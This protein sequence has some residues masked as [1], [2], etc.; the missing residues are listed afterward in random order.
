MGTWRA[1]LADVTRSATVVARTDVELMTLDR[2]HSG[3]ELA[4]RS[5]TANTVLRTVARRMADM[6]ATSPGAAHAATGESSTWHGR[7]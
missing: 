4:T 3:A 5:E 7:T 6:P 1:L 2:A